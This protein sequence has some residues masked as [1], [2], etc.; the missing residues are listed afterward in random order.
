MMLEPGTALGR[1]IALSRYPV[2]S[3][4]GE[5]L[6]QGTFSETGLL[7]DR[8]WGVVDA[9]TGQLLSAK[10]VP[11]LLD[12]EARTTAQGV[13]LTLPGGHALTAG[14]PGTDETLSEWLDRN[15]N[16]VEA[17][18][19]PGPSY[20]MS[21]N[22]DDETEDVFEVPTRPH[23]FLDLA[24]IH[25]LTIQALDE[26]RSHHPDGDWDAHR[27]RPTILVDTSAGTS[28]FVE[29]EWVGATIGT[30][31]LEFKVSMPT[32][33][34]TMTTRAQAA[35]DLERDLDIFK[36]LTRSNSQNLGAYAEITGAGTAR[37]GDELCVVES[38]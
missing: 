25:V 1:V 15:V 37:V 27:F 6:E 16:L 31:S 36:S 29:N 12:A 17:G 23:H 3:F 30:G 11:P 33:R 26:A 7:G 14:D 10:R 2:K 13:R 24:P 35:H 22:V 21:F 32:I 19:E 20:S 34:C 9:A 28:G 18:N 38:D 8:R 4:Q 5:A